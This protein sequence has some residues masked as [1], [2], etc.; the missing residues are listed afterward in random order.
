VKH[1]N[2]IYTLLGSI[3]T[4]TDLLQH[5]FSLNTANKFPDEVS[6]SNLPMWTCTQL[7]NQNQR[8]WNEIHNCIRHNDLKR[9]TALLSERT[10]NLNSFNPYGRWNVDDTLLHSAAV[11]KD[12][13]MMEFILH[14]LSP[15]TKA[16][17]AETKNRLGQ[18]PASLVERWTPSLH[19][20]YPRKFRQ[21]VK[22]VLILTAKRQDGTPYYPE[23]HFYKLPKDLLFQIL[24]YAAFSL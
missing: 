3:S 9:L 18:I 2:Q 21:M 5:S 15:S 20:L 8:M 17:M 11:S 6:P 12:V 7:V 19:S 23:A 4:V 16:R 1:S 22:T 13:K 24:Q 10:I 14:K